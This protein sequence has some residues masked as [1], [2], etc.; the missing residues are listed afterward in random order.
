MRPLTPDDL[1]DAT[2]WMRLR[3]RHRVAWLTDARLRRVA[4]APGLD[5]VFVD[6]EAVRFQLQELALAAALGGPCPP[7]APLLPAFNVLLPGDASLAAWVA[8]TDVD[9]APP[10]AP[11]AL[12]CEGGALRVGAWAEDGPSALRAVVFAGVERA[13]VAL[14]W[15]GARV[16]LSDGLRAALARDLDGGA[17]LRA[18]GVG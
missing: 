7:P 8:V 18:L 9:R 4:L 2:S 15:E 12:V 10:A 11:P 5:V 14:A 17:P 1:L 6:R 3:D 16:A 13:P